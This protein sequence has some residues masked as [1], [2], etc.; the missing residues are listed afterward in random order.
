MNI[1]NTVPNISLNLDSL[2]ILDLLYK[3]QN[4][5]KTCPHCNCTS[6]IKH[7]YYKTLQR[8]KCSN[9]ICNKT[10]CATTKSPWSYSKKSFDLWK[11]YFKL[12]FENK[13]L[14]ECST[15]LDIHNTT[16]FYWRHKILVA[17]KSFF[18]PQPLKEF[19]E[20]NKFRFKENF[21]GSR[22]IVTDERKYIWLISA[23]DINNTI[24]SELVSVGPI[25]IPIIKSSIYKKI[26]KDAY[27]LSSADTHLRAI[28]IIH[29]KNLTTPH[30]KDKELV[31]SFSKFIAPWLN[32]FK[33]IAT[34][35]LN[36]YLTW[37]ILNF[38]KYYNDF[39]KF[40]INLTLENSFTRFIDFKSFNL[41]LN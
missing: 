35:Y 28:E 21:K 15:T 37:Y 4:K 17:M 9:K 40:I 1:Y 30:P 25:S 12:M 26:P 32:R 16:A 24:L 29:N 6:F 20:I 23:V 2:N 38:K 41:S 3:R 5:I 33:G 39:M 13:T 36:S 7:G 31:R 8:F 34:K 10:F 11:D 22:N 14:I 19:I 27:L 18:K